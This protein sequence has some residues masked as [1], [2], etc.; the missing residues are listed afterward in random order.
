MDACLLCQSMR[1][2]HHFFSGSSSQGSF[3]GLTLAVWLICHVWHCFCR[4]HLWFPCIRALGILMWSLLLVLLIELGGCR[5]CLSFCGPLLS[6]S[7]SAGLSNQL[8]LPRVRPPFSKSCFPFLT[9]VV[10]LLCTFPSFLRVEQVMPNLSNV[11]VP[12][13]RSLFFQQFPA[14]SLHL[15]G[16]RRCCLI[17]VLSVSLWFSCPF[18]R[19]QVVCCQRLP[20]TKSLQILARNVPAAN[21]L[22]EH[23][24]ICSLPADRFVILLG[25][26]VENQMLLF[27]P[28]KLGSD[29]KKSELLN[30]DWIST[31]KWLKNEWSLES[32]F[33][34]FLVIFQST[35]SDFLW[36]MFC[37]LQLPEI[38]S[39]QRP[40]GYLGI[41][42]C[43]KKISANP[44]SR[45]LCVR[46]HCEKISTN[47]G[48]GYL[49]IRFYCRKI[50]T[51]PG[52]GYLGIRFYC[53][54]ISTNP[55]S[56]YLGIR[57]YCKKI[58]TNPGSGYLGIRFYCKKIS[59]NPGSGYLGIRFYYKKISTNP[60]SGYLGIRFY[61]K[62]ISTNPGSGYLGIRFYYEKISMNP[63][64]AYDSLLSINTV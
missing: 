53:K 12:F 7:A 3:W 63:G 21:F 60:G 59:T 36:P 33:S 8:S 48:S 62:K 61:C 40:S 28:L 10:L 56:G 54:K 29:W 26:R 55:G 37:R 19:Q 16:Q 23:G 2:S 24:L 30:F 38:C 35:H 58:R 43:C 14:S 34:C 57:F 5:C 32:F 39:P 9:A 50:S 17:W 25:F 42:F 6:A 4:M 18:Q 64:S 41:Q 51:N 27:P 11:R 1:L 47:P 22:L 20:P 52:S 46:F 15:L 49:G 13:R 44:G 31:E 45:H